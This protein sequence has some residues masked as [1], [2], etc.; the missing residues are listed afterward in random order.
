MVSGGC[1]RVHGRGRAVQLNGQSTAIQ[2]PEQRAAPEMLPW[3]SAV[4]RVP[5]VRVSFV[6][7]PLRVVV[8][9]RPAP[10]HLLLLL[11]RKHHRRRVSRRREHQVQVVP[12]VRNRQRD[13]RAVG[14]QVL[15]GRAGDAAGERVVPATRPRVQRA[16][17]SK[18]L[19]DLCTSCRSEL[20]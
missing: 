9:L 2:R 10:Y 8:P 12:A 19:L 15:H 18:R 5:S 1:G 14:S 13:R 7:G 4:C 3:G 17:R 6:A 20:P 11:P 16:L